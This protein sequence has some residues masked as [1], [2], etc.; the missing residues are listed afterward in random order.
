MIN[1]VS[2]ELIQDFKNLKNP[3]K[4]KNPINKQ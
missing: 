2:E 4:T 3:T 1:V